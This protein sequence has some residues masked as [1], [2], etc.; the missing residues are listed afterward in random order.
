VNEDTRPVGESAAFYVPGGTLRL[1]APSYVVRAADR[2]LHAAL[3]EGEFCYVLTSRQMGK[4]SLMVRT[5]ARLREEGAMVAVIDLTAVGLN[6]TPQQWYAGLLSHVGEQ[7]D[8]EDELDDFWM[9]QDALG[10]VQRWVAAIERVILPRTEGQLIFFVDEIDAVMSLS[11]SSDEFFAAIRSCHNRRV[12]SPELDR[13]TFC[14]IGVASPTDLNEDPRTTPF[15]IGRRI[16]LADLTEGDSG[17]LAQGLHSDPTTASSLLRRVL[18]WTNGHPYLTQ[19]L[20]HA[21]ATGESASTDADVDRICGDLFLSEAG[22]DQD[23]NLT[24]ARDRVLRSPEY[25]GADLAGL[26]TLYGDIHCGKRVAVDDSNP[27]VGILKLAG[28][29]RVDGSR[30]RVRNRIYDRVFNR[31][32]VR[33]S[34]PHAELRR[35]KQ[36]FWRG[37]QRVAAV[38]VVFAAIAVYAFVQSVRLRAVHGDLRHALAESTA[39]REALAATVADLRVANSVRLLENGDASGL[40]GLAETARSLLP[41]PD[42]RLLGATWAAWEQQYEG[43][44]QGIVGPEDGV[45]SFVMSP[46]ATWFATAGIRGAAQ[47]W[48]TADR[49]RHGPA[50]EHGSP[51]SDLSFDPMGRTLET[52]SDDGAVNLWNVEEASLRAT[53]RHPEKV[54]FSRF[55]FDGA[56]FATLTYSEPGKTVVRLWDTHTGE[57][58]VDPSSLDGVARLGPDAHLMLFDG[59]I[60]R[61]EIVDIATMERLS[62]ITLP[63]T[64]SSEGAEDASGARLVIGFAD[65]SIVHGSLSPASLPSGW[66]PNGDIQFGSRGSDATHHLFDAPVTVVSISGDGRIVAAMTGDPTGQIAVL[67][68]ATGEPVGRPIFHRS[69]VVGLQLSYDGSLLGGGAGD[70]ARVWS[71]ESGEDLT[72]A[73]TFPAASPAPAA[74]DRPSGAAPRAEPSEIR[75][76]AFS[77]GESPD[78]FVAMENAAPVYV[79]RVRA[80]DAAETVVSYP[81]GWAAKLGL[82]ADDTTLVTCSTAGPSAQVWDADSGSAQ[83]EVLALPHGGINLTDRIVAVAPDGS[84]FAVRTLTNIQQYDSASGEPVGPPVSCGADAPALAYSPDGAFLALAD[85]SQVRFLNRV[86]SGQTA[87]VDVGARIADLAFSPSGTFLAVAVGA[88][89]RF[90]AYP[91]GEEVFEAIAHSR[92]IAHLA[93]DAG[94]VLLAT[95]TRDNAAR[96]WDIATGVALGPEIR[97]AAR[98]DDIAFAP[99]RLA[100]ATAATDS[101]VRFWDTE[102]GRPHGSPISVPGVVQEIAFTSDGST[103]F[104]GG[105]SGRVLRWRLPFLPATVGEMERRTRATTGLRAGSGQSI[106]RVTPVEWAALQAE[107]R[108]EPIKH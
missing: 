88:E 75:S 16:E 107:M 81:G 43:R 47:L 85:S 11:F 41:G 93:L 86:D 31:A 45:S 12:E 87:S 59:S 57:L 19:R 46:N 63:S 69:P 64:I 70:T 26:L 10:P 37:V 13:L 28:T 2:E 61:A 94:G 65:G 77:R 14:L 102:T 18:H 100:V 1:E 9:E 82:S 67:H 42:L 92:P 40:V 80:T 55:T 15:N 104:T 97:H 101:R 38:I 24:F 30:L 33:D 32:W 54:Q 78:L 58:V 52:R 29:V 21:I 108:A 25:D 79:Y 72:G 89:V 91:T 90:L 105:R 44:L 99:K 48:R 56:R 27:L 95:V 4:S 68:A 3:T 84:S 36:A 20:C 83:S 7:L 22:R 5:A 60:T 103:M 106:L 66:P 53:L 98:V 8:L 35:Q 17:G 62:Y 73:L 71:T 51:I 50:L 96:A 6:L 74:G 23:T 34:M 39:D 49:T 76:V